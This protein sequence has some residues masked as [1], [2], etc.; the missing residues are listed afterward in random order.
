MA[1]QTEILTEIRE[2]VLSIQQQ[3]AA[4]QEKL[5]RYEPLLQRYEK[6]VSANGFFEARRAMKRKDTEN[7]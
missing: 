7:A 6:A 3:I 4:V 5:E 2:T 1:T